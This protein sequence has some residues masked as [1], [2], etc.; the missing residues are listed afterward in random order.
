MVSEPCPISSALENRWRET[1]SYSTAASAKKTRTHA[2]TVTHRHTDTS[3]KPLPS[4]AQ[5][6]LT[7]HQNIGGPP[8]VL[9]PLQR[10][11]YQSHVSGE[12]PSTIHT[13]VT[14]PKTSVN[15]PGLLAPGLRS[16]FRLFR[17]FGRPRGRKL[18]PQPELGARGG[19]EET[20][21]TSCTHR[22][23]A[24]SQKRFQRKIAY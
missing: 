17:G 9:E 23:G 1:A 11:P 14:D 19:G 10:R 15:A 16:L 20:K 7:G 13:K 8:C 24:L 22:S 2:H 3:R 5:S 4:N 18:Y 6:T 12:G 21:E